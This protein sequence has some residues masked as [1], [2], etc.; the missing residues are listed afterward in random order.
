MHDGGQSS[1]PPDRTPQFLRTHCARCGVRFS[2]PTELGVEPIT[3]QDCCEQILVADVDFGSREPV[4]RIMQKAEVAP[5]SEYDDL[6]YHVEP[7]KV[8]EPN[9]E[10]LMLLLPF[11]A[12]LFIT[13]VTAIWWLLFYS[14]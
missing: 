8:P 9:D 3:C 7:R 2:S 12:L 13:V 4:K 1:V 6:Y 10:A 11:V 14:Y 5:Q